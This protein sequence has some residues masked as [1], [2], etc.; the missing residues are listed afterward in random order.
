MCIFCPCQHTVIITY[1]HKAAKRR[2]ATWVWDKKA[3][4]AQEGYRLAQVRTQIIKYSLL[5][6]E[7][8]F[9]NVKMYYLLFVTEQQKILY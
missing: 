8:T 6:Q 9:T 5:K 7:S 1:P 4:A 2:N 3:G